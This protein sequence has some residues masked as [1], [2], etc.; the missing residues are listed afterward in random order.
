MSSTGCI[1]YTV[2]VANINTVIS[3][4]Y[5]GTEMVKLAAG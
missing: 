2:L 5:L 1:D 3:T 4:Y